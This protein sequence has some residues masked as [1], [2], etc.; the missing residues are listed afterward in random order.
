MGSNVELLLL[1]IELLWAFSSL[2]ELLDYEP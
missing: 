2:M 1:S